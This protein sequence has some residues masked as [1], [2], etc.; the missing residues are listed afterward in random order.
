M[1]NLDMSEIV[2]KVSE[3]IPTMGSFSEVFFKWFWGGCD[4][5]GARMDDEIF[6]ISKSKATY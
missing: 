3:N 5:E 1:K 6:M 4:R 2:I